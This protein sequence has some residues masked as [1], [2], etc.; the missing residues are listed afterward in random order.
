MITS[1]DNPNIKDTAKLMRSAKYRHDKQM[2]VA[3]GV[4]LCLDGVLSGAHIET[5]FYTEKAKEKYAEDFFAISSAAASS[6]EVSEEVFGKISDTQ[7]PQGLISVFKMLDKSD[8]TYKISNQGRYVALE[9]LQDPTNLGTIL[10]TAEALGIDGVILSRDCCDVYSPKVVRASMGAVFRANIFI[11]ENFTEYIKKLTDGG[12]FTYGSTPRNA[13]D[14]DELNVSGGVMIVG[15]EG[16]GL[17]EETLAVC[18]QRV[19]IPMRGR[20]E[21]LNAA[22]AAS[23]LMWEMFRRQ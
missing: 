8:L 3:E 2:F 12:V 18:T 21:S 14:I 23:I 4:R 1:K 9:N 7:T 17:K 13:Q 15:N 11:A 19:K 20:A 5:L 16:A 6:I 22:A 10:R